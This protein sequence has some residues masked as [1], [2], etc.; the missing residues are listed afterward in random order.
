[1]S[2][3]RQQIAMATMLVALFAPRIKKF[4]GLDIDVETALDLLAAA[5]LTWHGLGAAVDK[6][7]PPPWINRNPMKPVNPAKETS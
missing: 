6:Y 2:G 4:T 7:F 5:A 1:M 3:N